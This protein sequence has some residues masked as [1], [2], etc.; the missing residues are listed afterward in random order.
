MDWLA[1]LQQ[2]QNIIFG[3]SVQLQTGDFDRNN[4]T[5]RKEFWEGDSYALADIIFA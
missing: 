4:V 1:L 3:I 5:Y 2:K